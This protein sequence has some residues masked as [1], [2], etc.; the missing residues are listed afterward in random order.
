MER[1]QKIEIFSEVLAGI[2]AEAMDKGMEELS[3]EAFKLSFDIYGKNL[4]MDMVEEQ[5]KGFRARLEAND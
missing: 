1:W 5:I 4:D 2:S 3:N